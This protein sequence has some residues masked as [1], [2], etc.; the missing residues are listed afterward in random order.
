MTRRRFYSLTELV[1]VMTSLVTWI[2]RA[3]SADGPLKC[4][5]VTIPM[6]RGIGYNHTYTPNQ[7]HHDTQV[8]NNLLKTSTSIIQLHAVHKDDYL[9]W[10]N[11]SLSL[12]T[13]W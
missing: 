1:A 4:V 9:H 10:L 7:F 13:L 12:S 2:I 11:Q 6:C 5:D 8:G 3:G